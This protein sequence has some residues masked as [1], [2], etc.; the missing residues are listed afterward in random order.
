MTSQR[1]PCP[2]VT[3]Q[4]WALAS[5]GTDARVNNHVAEI[6]QDLD[7]PKCEIQFVPTTVTRRLR[8]AAAALPHR[9]RS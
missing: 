7:L 3:P 9:L 8:G 1:P 6:I 2:D 4:T 5:T